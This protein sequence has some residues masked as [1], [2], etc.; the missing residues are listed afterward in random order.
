VVNRFLVFKIS[1]PG[2]F[3][4]LPG[5][6]FRGVFFSKILNLALLPHPLASGLFIQ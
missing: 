3:V 2:V 5:Q 6:V 4:A 1:T